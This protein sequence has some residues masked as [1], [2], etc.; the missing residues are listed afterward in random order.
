[1]D[2]VTTFLDDLRADLLRA[3]EALGYEPPS[4]PSALDAAETFYRLSRRLISPVPRRCHR[5]AALKRH[6]LPDWQARAVLEITGRL[7]RG[8]DVR[9][10]LS[11]QTRDLAPKVA[12]DLLLNDWGVHHLHLGSAEGST[13]PEADGYVPRSKELLYLHVQ[14]RDVYLL[15][16]K[17]HQAFEDVDL[18]EILHAN[19]PHALEPYRCPE[20][21]EHHSPV[22]SPGDLR[23]FRKVGLTVAVQARDGTVYMPPGG[24]YMTS[25]ASAVAAI[26]TIR[27]L[28]RTRQLA[29]WCESRA[30]IIRDEIEREVG[31]PIQNL[32]LRLRTGWRVMEHLEV[33]D[34][35][36]NTR[37]SFRDGTTVP[38][39]LLRA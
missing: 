6:A 24:G 7:A 19:W 23:K 1:M 37:I 13:A 14:P 39:A 10:F 5:S 17:H 22:Q 15:D 16:V 30:A 4:N 8:E 2:L 26:H 32:R 28:S 12:H 35:G 29:E 3:I 31:R 20:V 11:R 34:A 21:V 36:T 9:A 33:W 27:L 25:G 18:V 38:S